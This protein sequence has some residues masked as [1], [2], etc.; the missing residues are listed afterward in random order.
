MKMDPFKAAL[1]SVK[2]GFGGREGREH[3]CIRKRWN[4]T[5]GIGQV[6]R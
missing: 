3:E 2:K 1:D 4:D 5:M 6:I